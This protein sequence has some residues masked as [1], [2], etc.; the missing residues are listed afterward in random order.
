MAKAVKM[1]KEGLKITEKLA[2]VVDIPKDSPSFFGTRIRR[3]IETL[4]ISQKTAQRVIEH[5]ERL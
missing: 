4:R 5:D 3:A 2:L 1:G